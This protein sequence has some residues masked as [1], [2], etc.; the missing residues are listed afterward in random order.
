MFKCQFAD[1]G[2]TGESAAPVPR[3]RVLSDADM[4]IAPPPN[5][6]S[7]VA[8]SAGPRRLFD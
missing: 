4:G 2:I 7:D 3:G 5:V 8:K 6:A 1:M